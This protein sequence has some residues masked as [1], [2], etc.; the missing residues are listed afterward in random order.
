M[1]EKLDYYPYFEDLVTVTLTP[2]ELDIAW[3]ACTLVK[4]PRNDD[5]HFNDDYSEV[6]GLLGRVYQEWKETTE[7]LDG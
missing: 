2:R 4:R 1:A 7:V 3:A 6:E 5:D